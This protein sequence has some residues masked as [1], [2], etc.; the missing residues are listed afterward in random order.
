[1]A[2]GQRM[3]AVDAQFYWM[4]AKV[5]SDQFLLYAFEGEPSRYER[6]VEDVCRRARAC[7]EFTMR[8]SDDGG[9]K[10]PVWVPAT[11]GPERVVRHDAADWGECLST[12]AGLPRDQLDVRRTPWRLH[13]FGPV[14]GVPGVDG[15]GTVAVLQ[16]PHALSPAMG[17]THGVHGIGDTIAI[18]VHA[19][20]SAVPDIDAYME[21]LDGLL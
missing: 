12:V 11:V 21:L 18:S 10:Y 4:S 5:P 16:V 1:M 8:L 17:L 6:A 19:A 3:T 20:E 2:A 13:V 14:L 9:P 15:P 7:P